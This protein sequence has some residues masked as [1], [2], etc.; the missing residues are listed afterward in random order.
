VVHYGYWGRWPAAFVDRANAAFRVP[1]ET[2]LL[3]ASFPC[4]IA[5]TA[6]DPDLAGGPLPVRW[7][8]TL[9]FCARLNGGRPVL[10]ALT[11]LLFRNSRRSAGARRR[12]FL[13]GITEPVTIFFARFVSH[14]N[15]RR[16]HGGCCADPWRKIHGVQLSWGGS[17]V[18]AIPAAGY[19]FGQHLA[20]WSGD[21]RRFRPWWPRFCVGGS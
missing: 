15:H 6:T 2:I 3:L 8:K 13:P 18:T 9:G 11:G 16:A 5:R 12:L 10:G 19:C 1:G 21:I 7:A 17:L 20:G 14:A 4:I